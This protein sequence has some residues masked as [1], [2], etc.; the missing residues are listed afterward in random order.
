MTTTLD[1]TPEGL[2]RLIERQCEINEQVGR[3]REVLASEPVK[4]AKRLRRRLPSW[5]HAV[6]VPTTGAPVAVVS[7]PPGGA[8]AIRCTRW[9]VHVDRRGRALHVV[10]L[11]GDWMRHAVETVMRIEAGGVPVMDAALRRTA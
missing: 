3:V 9:N 4:L 11:R 8:Y 2:A 1:Y 5:S 10:D 6:D 7:T